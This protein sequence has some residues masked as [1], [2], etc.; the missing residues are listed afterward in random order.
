M[1]LVYKR[2]GAKGFTVA[3][4]VVVLGII[5]IL[6]AL[7]TTGASWARCRASE[8]Q[9][10]SRASHLDEALELFHIKHGRYPSAYPAELSTRLAPYLEEDLAEFVDN[11]EAFVARAL[12]P[13]A[14]APSTS[15]TRHRRPWPPA[16][17][18]RLP[19]SRG[20]RAPAQRSSSSRMLSEWSRRSRCGMA[21]PNSRRQMWSRAAS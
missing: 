17:A 15:P 2:G 19:S 4:V 6:A 12:P 1:G 9:A 13:P 5:S 14:Q 3:E 20:I 18:T 11:V 21:T 7:V 10:A 8:V 16:A